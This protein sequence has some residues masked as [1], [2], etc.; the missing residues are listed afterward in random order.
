MLLIVPLYS[1]DA[2]QKA[3]KPHIGIVC[4]AFL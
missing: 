4:D 1:D 3:H 2:I